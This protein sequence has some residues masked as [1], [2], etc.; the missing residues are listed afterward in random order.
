M[1]VCRRVENVLR[2]V[3][4][5]D[6][7]HH[8]A[9]GDVGDYRLRLYPGPAVAHHQPDVVHRGLSLVDQHE[10]RRSIG[11]DLPNHLRAY[12]PRRPGDHHHVA[13]EQSC[14][15][16]HVNLYLLARQQVLNVDRMKVADTEV[17]LP[18]PLTCLRHHHDLDTRLHKGV[19]QILALAQ[20][21]HHQRRHYQCPRLHPPH[22]VYKVVVESPHLHAHEPAVLHVRVGAHEP[23]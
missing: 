7:L 21:V 1:L 22:V 11:R 15:S 9:V 2:A 19:H 4:V 12:A 23:A 3:F 10:M 17:G 8:P 5:K 20:F 6:P 14:R 13:V 18:V 16:L